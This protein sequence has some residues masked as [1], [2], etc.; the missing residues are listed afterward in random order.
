MENSAKMN[1]LKVKLDGFVDDFNGAVGDV[2][3][4]AMND[5]QASINETLKE[6]KTAS[7]DN[8]ISYLKGVEKPLIEA[9]KLLDYPVY[10]FKVNR[11]NG[12]VIDGQ[13]VPAK[14]PIDLVKVCERFGLD[15]VWQY[16]VEAIARL[17]ALRVAKDLECK[18]SDINELSEK[19]RMSTQAKKLLRE[20]KDPTSNNQLV[21]HLQK[22]SDKVF[23]QIGKI[24]NKD[25]AFIREAF[26]KNGRERGSISVG[27]GR[28]MHNL[29]ATVCHNVMLGEG[30]R[31]EYKKVKEKNDQAANET[32]TETVE[33]PKPDE[34]AA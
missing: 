8:T 17:F 21:T 12:V 5:A 24:N 10:K 33:V 4:V 1:E 15:T 23:G 3:L 11:E 19:Y 31:V 34:K 2:S 22:L 25:L 14:A 9:L 32:K 13:L 7:F 27:T 16:D 26:T 6:Y 28:L 18:D 20:G 29:F 30:Y